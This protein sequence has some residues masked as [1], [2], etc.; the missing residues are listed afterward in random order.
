MTQA[1]IKKLA[2]KWLAVKP[3]KG[4]GRRTK[5]LLAECCGVST[6][7]ISRLWKGMASAPTLAAVETF[8]TSF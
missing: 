8:L 6:S 7:E 3:P 2:E 4:Y 5:K 1:R